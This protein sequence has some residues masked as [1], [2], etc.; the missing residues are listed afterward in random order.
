MDLQPKQIT[1]R[2]SLTRTK[3]NKQQQNEN[4][5]NWDLLTPLLQ[6]YEAQDANIIVIDSSSSEYASTQSDVVDSQSTCLEFTPPGFN[7][8][9]FLVDGEE[10]GDN[11]TAVCAAEC[12]VAQNKR[13]PT[14]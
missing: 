11:I 10:P 3:R 13:Q 4:S 2:L 6:Q 5:K 8:E 14:M 12:N 9:D 1:S 7:E